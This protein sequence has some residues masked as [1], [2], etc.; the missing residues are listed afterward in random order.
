MGIK[1]DWQVEAERVYQRAGEDPQERA[2]RRQQRLRILFFTFGVMLA[3][4]GLGA[5]IWVRLYTVDDTIKRDLIRTVQ[6]ETV[7]LRVGDLAQFMKIQRTADEGKAWYRERGEVFKRYQDLKTKSD[8]NLTGNVLDATIDNSR[9]RAVVEEVIDGK[10]YE[11]VWFYW[12]YPDGWRHVPSDYTFWGEPGTIKGMNT[13]INYNDLDKEL[14]QILAERVDKWWIQ[15]CNTLGCR[16]TPALTVQIAPEPGA[17]VRWDEKDENLLIV[18]SPLA[19]GDRTLADPL[20]QPVVEDTIAR[21]IAE[22]Q[23]G[24]ATGNLQPQTTVD[25]SWLRETTINWLAGSYTGRGDTARL[26]FIQS[27]V[28]NY[29]SGGLTTLLHLI[30]PSS[31]IDVLSQAL[32]QPL[33]TLSLDWKSFFQWRLDVEKTLLSRSDFPN[34]QK[35]WDIDNPEAAQQMRVRANRPQQATPQVQAFAINK[36]A[37]RIVRATVQTTADGQQLIIIFRLVNGEWKRSA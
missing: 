33:E 12:R 7:T 10:R 31:N 19:Q 6:A 28:D 13:T 15:G 29:G 32:N 24:L 36:G 2:N 5:A 18:P 21:S 34:F 25:A 30:T 35:L 11:T 16:T 23:F 17:Q 27:L 8:V 14:A 20:L 37:D 22:R 9:G 4:C 1:L 26:S 3:V